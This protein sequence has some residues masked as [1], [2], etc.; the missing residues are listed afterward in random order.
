METRLCIEDGSTGLHKVA[1]IGSNKSGF[2]VVCPYQ[3]SR[4]GQFVLTRVSDKLGRQF[5][6]PRDV[7]IASSR[8]K[9]SFHP[10]N[11]EHP[12]K[13]LVHFS[14]AGIASGFDERGNPRG[15][16]LMGPPMPEIHTGPTFGMQFWGLDHFDRVKPRDKHLLVFPQKDMHPPVNNGFFNSYHIECFLLPNQLRKARK[17]PPAFFKEYVFEGAKKGFDLKVIELP[18]HDSFLGLVCLR[19]RITFNGSSGYT[20]NSPRLHDWMIFATYPVQYQ[21]GR[22][23]NLDYPAAS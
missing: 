18:G 1:L 12:D 6:A 7:Y 4:Q 23:T 10:P 2:Y 15:L 9:L 17:K 16:A 20:L 19:R 8:A 13:F 21:H 22:A 14:G 11:K 3:K 5:S